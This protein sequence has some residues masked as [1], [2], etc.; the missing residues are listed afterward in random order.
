MLLSI[1]LIFSQFQPGIIYKSAAYNKKLSLKNSC[2]FS[3]EVISWMLH[4]CCRGGICCCCCCCCFKALSKTKFSW[5]NSFPTA[6]LKSC[7]GWSSSRLTGV[8]GGVKMLL[9]TQEIDSYATF[10]SLVSLHAF[11]FNF[12]IQGYILINSISCSFSTKVISWML[13]TYC[14]GSICCCC[15]CCCF[16]TLTKSEI[17]LNKF[18]LGL[19]HN[20]L[21]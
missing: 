19:L 6:S 7:S 16:K 20:W 21:E 12:H 18:F 15:C 10:F 17:F 4:A 2:P 5:I 9:N 1:C 14:R 11:Y 3:T 8:D 13:N